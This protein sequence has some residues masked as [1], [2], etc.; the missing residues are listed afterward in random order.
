MKDNWG[1]FWV[2]FLI[3]GFITFCFMARDHYEQRNLHPQI[4][5]AGQPG[6]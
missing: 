3:G 4:E 6:Y 2:G 1:M 5:D